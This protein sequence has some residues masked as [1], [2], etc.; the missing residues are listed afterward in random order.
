MYIHMGAHSDRV[1][2][3]GVD[4]NTVGTLHCVLRPLRI[5]DIP[6]LGTHL[7]LLLHMSA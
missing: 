7:Y 2:S 3:E 1:H 5:N 4:K 6:K